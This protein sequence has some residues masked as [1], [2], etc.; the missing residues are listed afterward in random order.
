MTIPRQIAILAGGDSTRMGRDKAAI[1]YDGE[2]LL[3]RIARRATTAADEVCVVG[4]ERPEDWPLAHVPFV[5]DRFPDRGPLEGLRCALRHFRAPTALVACDMP[6]LTSE[7]LDWLLET[8]RSWAEASTG[9]SQSHGLIVRRDEHPEPLFSVYHPS[10]LDLVDQRLDDRQYAMYGL[11][12]AGDF[13]NRTVPDR[14]A[15]QLRNVN[16]PEE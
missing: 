3:V 15:D 5:P 8:H 2:P 4:R 6:L 7:A 12:A 14:F 1:R 13:V 10:V 9:S 16:T 11:I